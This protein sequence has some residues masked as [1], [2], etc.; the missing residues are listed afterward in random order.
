MPYSRCSCSSSSSSS[1]D[2]CSFCL[3]SNGQDD[4]TELVRKVLS[5]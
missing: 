1:M 3:I 2:D 4:F 5:S